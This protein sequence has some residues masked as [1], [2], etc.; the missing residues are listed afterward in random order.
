MLLCATQ[1]DD[2][3]VEA[4]GYTSCIRLFDVEATGPRIHWRSVCCT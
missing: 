2:G 1:S 4:T 3:D